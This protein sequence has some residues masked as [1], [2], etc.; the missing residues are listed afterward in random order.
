[1]DIDPKDQT[2]LARALRRRQAEGGQVNV[3]PI[4][5]WTSYL[6]PD[7]QPQPIAQWSSYLDSGSSASLTP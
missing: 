5:R 4:A 1:M 2:V 3:A 7:E 6:D